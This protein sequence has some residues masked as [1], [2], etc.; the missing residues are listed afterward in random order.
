MEEKLFLF[1]EKKNGINIPGFS[2]RPYFPSLDCD[3]A[4]RP[5]RTISAPGRR[6]FLFYFCCN[7]LGGDQRHPFLVFDHTIE[8][9]ADVPVNRGD[10]VSIFKL[11]FLGRIQ[12]D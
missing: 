2:G 8:F 10:I 9:N 3:A 12:L 11:H 1:L 5:D 7:F 6:P 4:A